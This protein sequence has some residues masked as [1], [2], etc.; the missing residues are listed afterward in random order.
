MSQ[1]HKEISHLNINSKTYSENYDEIDW[2]QLND[3]FE[4]KKKDALKKT[5]NWMEM[6]NEKTCEG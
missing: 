3:T 5:P 4:D 2:S 1:N 6:K